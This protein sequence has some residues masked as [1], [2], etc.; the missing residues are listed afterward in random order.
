METAENNLGKSDRIIDQ[1]NI[2]VNV[3]EHGVMPDG[4]TLN[5]AAIQNLI[6]QCREAGGGT[7]FFP[8]GRYLTGGLV[9]CSNLT[10]Y[11][12][13]GATLLGSGDLSHYRHWTPAPVPFHEGTEGVRAILFALDCENIRITGQ[14]TID[15]QGA[16]FECNRAVRAGRPRNIWFARCRDIAVDGIRLRNSGFW[17][18]HYMKCVKVRLTN[19][20]VWNHG[21]VNSD[22]IDIDCCRDVII[23]NCRIDSA[24]D[25]ICLKSG[26]DTPTENVLVTAC[27][28]RSHCNHFKTGTESNGGFKNIMVDGLIMTPSEQ[29]ESHRGTEGADWRGACGIAITSVDGGFLENIVIRNIQ[30][31]QVR[32]PF[33]IRLGDRGRVFSPGGVRQPVSYG[34]DI[35]ICNIQARGAS[36]STCHISGLPGTQLCNIAIEN[37]DLQFAGGGDSALISREIPLNRSGY[38]SMEMFGSLPAYGIF[39]RDVEALTL[40]NLRF[41]LESPD[42]RP[43]LQ[44]RDCRRVEI[45]GIQEI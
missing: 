25:A 13:N 42:P 38:P 32:V 26:N 9:L 37:C 33:F 15:G 1:E 21:G 27:L 14:G 35:S 41:R 40:R 2:M 24:D 23:N 4:Q 8:P 45:S 36:S 43:A 16:L 39:A 29:T 31:D 7:L 30:M 12:E 18:Q 10:L 5:T 44:W 20:D 3:I 22:G 6:D 19:L 17:M 34:R 11:L 28:T